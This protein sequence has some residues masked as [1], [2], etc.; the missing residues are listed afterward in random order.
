[1]VP[2]LSRIRTIERVPI[3]Q[4]AKQGLLSQ[5]HSTFFNQPGILFFRCHFHEYMES[6]SVVV[7]HP[8]YAITQKSGEF[9][10]SDIPPE[11]YTLMACH[12]LGTFEIPIHIDAHDE[13]TIDV[14][15]SPTVTGA[16]QEDLS[17][18]N[19]FGI[20]LVGDSS[21]VPTVELQKWELGSER[22]IGGGS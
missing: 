10:I 14:E 21:I 15:L 22:T 16:H 9:A 12:P 1:M 5:A 18:P 13:L 2:T 4:K 7:P 20:D 3:S 17:T 6:W 11:S 19:P 8:Y